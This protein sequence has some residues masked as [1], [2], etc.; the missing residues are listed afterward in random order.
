[1]SE[2]RKLARLH[3][4]KTEAAGF[5]GVSLRFFNKLLSKDS[6]VAR[7]WED[8]K[9][10]GKVSLRRKQ[11]RLASTNA[12]MAIFL[13]KQYLGQ[14]DISVQE[15]SGRDGKPIQFDV[16]KLEIDDRKKLRELIKRTKSE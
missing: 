6:R 1:M 11:M 9:Q 10:E 2:V 4:T 16:S 13:G 14:Q 8:G 12:S 3:C 5:L 7:A 15:H